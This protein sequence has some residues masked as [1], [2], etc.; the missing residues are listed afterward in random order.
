MDLGLPRSILLT[1]LIGC[2]LAGFVLAAITQTNDKDRKKKFGTSLKTL[3]WDP[4]K[5][6]TAD[7]D[8][9]PD[10]RN[11]SKNVADPDA[12][13]KLETLLVTFDLTVI[14][15]TNGQAITGLKQE[16][17][18]LIDEGRAQ[19]I[20]LFSRGS[21]STAPRSIV[22]LMDYSTSMNAYFDAS[23]KAAKKLFDQLEPND[24]IAVVTD[25]VELLSPPSTNKKHAMQALDELKGRFRD[26]NRGKSRQFSALFSVL[27]E[28][29]NSREEQTIIIFQTDGDEVA[30]LRDSKAPEL[31]GP[32]AEFGFIDIEIAAEKTGVTIYG[33]IPGERIVGLAYPEVHKIAQRTMNM[34][35]SVDAK[36]IPTED[37]WIQLILPGQA[38]IE[39][40]TQLTGGKTWYL[41]EPKQADDIYAEILSDMNRRYFIG[42]YP[43]GVE[44][45]G[46]RR[47]VGVRVRNHPEYEVRGRLAFYAP[48]RRQIREYQK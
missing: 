21:N 10:T 34:A 48:D 47:Q 44:G 3:K 43:D 26:H 19:N 37:A 22:L 18:E 35:R 27:R 23:I 8:P 5:R 28:M 15:R 33:V 41:K 31:Y 4:A 39:H 11:A 46:K 12:P 14:D 7:R 45:D 36:T 20:S 13:V 2:L 16:D 29:I 40:M 42:Y 25:D 1:L 9:S 38:S 30:K 24:K 32:P 17:F 6:R